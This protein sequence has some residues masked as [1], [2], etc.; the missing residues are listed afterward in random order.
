MKC[1]A[2]GAAMRIGVGIVLAAAFLGA[3]CA[4]SA[5]PRFGRPGGGHGC[6][7]GYSQKQGM[8]FCPTGYQ[9]INHMCVGPGHCPPGWDTSNGQCR[10]SSSCATGEQLI[11][12]HCVGAGGCPPGGVLVEGATRQCEATPT[13]PTGYRLQGDKCVA[14]V[15]SDFG[16]P[17][18]R[19]AVAPASRRTAS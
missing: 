18:V 14:P 16:G 17:P 10:P 12:G 2:G 3:A 8:C 19:R 1:E 4:S 13:C 5:A 11:H 15:R 9:V 7:W 6:G